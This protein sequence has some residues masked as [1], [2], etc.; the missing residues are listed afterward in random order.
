[1]PDVVHTMGLGARSL[2]T[3]LEVLAASRART[4]V[5]VRRYGSSARHPHQQAEVLHGAFRERGFEV[6]ALGDLLG[7]DRTGGYPR[8]METPAFRRGLERL[9]ALAAA[10]PTMVLCA[11]LAPERCHRRF[12]GAALEERGWSVAHHL[13]ALSERTARGQM[14]LVRKTG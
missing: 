4:V 11:E 1:V 5:D 14:R 7:G 9:E 2:E 10:A 3:I 8:Y 6:H 13:S 12:L